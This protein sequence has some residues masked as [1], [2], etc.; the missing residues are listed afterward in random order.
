MWP[1]SIR[2]VLQL[3]F[4]EIVEK[5]VE[6]VEKVGEIVENL[7]KTPVLLHK[8]TKFSYKVTILNT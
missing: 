3:R 7:W 4:V 1:H 5:V 6:I 8:F 2:I